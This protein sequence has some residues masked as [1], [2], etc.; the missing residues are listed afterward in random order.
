MYLCQVRRCVCNLMERPSREGDTADMGEAKVL[1]EVRWE[2]IKRTCQLPFI[3]RE[4][5]SQ[6]NKSKKGVG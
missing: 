2:K 4:A 6:F 1:E 3:G 5:T